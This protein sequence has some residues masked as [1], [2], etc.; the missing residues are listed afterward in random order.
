MITLDLSD[1]GAVTRATERAAEKVP[2]LCPFLARAQKAVPVAGEVSVLFTSDSEIRRLNQAFRGKDKATDVLS[3]P[4]PALP[5]STRK[6]AQQTIAGDL[7]ISIDTARRQ[8]HQ[9]GHPLEIELKIL[10]LHGLLHL[11][12]YDHETDAGEMAHREDQLRRR[13]RLPGT[14]I[15]RNSVENA[16]T[17]SRGRR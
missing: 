6:P 9:F 7:A 5:R 8:A 4:A 2:D 10:L 15:A 1:E 13:F 16:A 11:A 12:G 3:F 17:H 14:L